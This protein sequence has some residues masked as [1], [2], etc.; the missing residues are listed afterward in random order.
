MSSI[1]RTVPVTIPAE[2]AWRRLADVGAVNQLLTFL[3]DV[4]VEGD[5]RRCSLGDMG[6]LDEVILSVDDTNRRVAYTIVSAPLP[7]EHHSSAMQL[8][9]D[10]TGGTVLSWT[11]DFLPASI[12][13]QVEGLIDQGV[14]SLTDTLGR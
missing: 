7:F 2:E 6:A 9:P 12:A 8:L 13:P 1:V 10:G 14:R 11:T 4:T 5:S 3:G